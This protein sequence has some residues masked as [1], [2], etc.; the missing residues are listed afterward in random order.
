MAARMRFVSLSG[1]FETWCDVVDEKKRAV[2]ADAEVLR[3]AADAVGESVAAAEGQVA[4]AEE[5]MAAA[6]RRVV[7]AVG[8]SVAA[9]EVAERRVVEA[10]EESNAAAEGQRRR[11]LAR[12]FVRIANRAISA[13]F[14]R[15]VEVGR[16][17]TFKASS[18]N[19]SAQLKQLS[20]AG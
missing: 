19:I 18:T 4:A 20:R 1:A 14:E 6:E 13:A 7:E 8:E 11:A 17:S 5:G 2:E 16:C 10:V 12:V 9:A 15:W 3:R